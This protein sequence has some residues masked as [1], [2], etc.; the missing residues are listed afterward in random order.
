MVDVCNKN[1][2]FSSHMILMRLL[3]LSSLYCIRHIL[4][5]EE[6]QRNMA[7]RRAANQKMIKEADETQ[8]QTL[9][10]VDRIKQQTALTEELGAATLEELRAQGRQMDDINQDITAVNAK[11]DTASGLQDRFDRWSGNIF[12][13]KKRAAERE[14]DSEIA[15]RAREEMQ[16]IKEMFENEKYD[17]FSRTWKSAGMSLCNNPSQKAPELFDPNNQG[18]QMG[19]TRWDIDFGFAGID[20]EGWTYAADLAYLNKH[21]AGTPEPAWN[22]KARRRKWKY[23][24]KTGNEVIDG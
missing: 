12:G 3:F 4:T 21:G 15:E 14:A 20:R 8:D 5:Q 18:G 23:T 17:M 2:K 16:N 10:A 11:L 6:L 19:N 24:E 7:E 9:A 13:F 22:S 1:K